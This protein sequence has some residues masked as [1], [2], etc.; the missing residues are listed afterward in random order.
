MDGMFGGGGLTPEQLQALMEFGAGQGAFSEQDRAIQQQ[1]AQAD[2]LRNRHLSQ[3][4][5][6]IGG[7]LG[8]MGDILNAY[9]GKRDQTAARAQ[10]TVL[11]QARIDALR[12]LAAAYG[13]QGQPGAGFLGAP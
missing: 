7:G 9:V 3:H 6:G 12:K 2:A 11:Q 5:T 8:A 10:D 13:Q 1:L 4:S